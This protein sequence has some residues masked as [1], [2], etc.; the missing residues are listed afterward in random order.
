M[1]ASSCL[2]VSA[3]TGKGLEDVVSAIIER[4]PPPTGDKQGRLRMLLFDAVHDEFRS[5]YSGLAVLFVF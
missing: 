5:L 1:D 4:V 3:K 2:K